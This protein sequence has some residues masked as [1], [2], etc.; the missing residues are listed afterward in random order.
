MDGDALL[1]P[2]L[3]LV[4]DDDGDAL[5]VEELLIDSGEPFRTERV[6]SVAAALPYIDKVDCALVDLGLPDAQGLS[7]LNALTASAPDVAI[8]VLTGLNDRRRGIESLG[9]GAQDYL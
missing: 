4:E 3:L 2:R 1:G 5:I 9:E 8:V 6:T 7:A